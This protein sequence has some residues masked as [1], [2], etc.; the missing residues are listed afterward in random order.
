M[1][2]AHVHLVPRNGFFKPQSDLADDKQGPD[3]LRIT[4][5]D[6]GLGGVRQIAVTVLLR[7]KGSVA[8][9]CC[10]LGINSARNA[11]WPG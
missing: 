3:P 1:Q 10:R 8:Y 4:Q 9:F 2:C 6:L 11:C 5:K 7:S